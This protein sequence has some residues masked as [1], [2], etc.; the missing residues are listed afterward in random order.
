MKALI[1]T[2]KD[3]S[4][5]IFARHGWSVFLYDSF[6]ER[7]I[8]GEQF[9][10]VYFRDPFNDDSIENYKYRI[11]MV[12][13]Q[14]SEAKSIDEIRS[15]DD[16]KRI[17]DK[18]SQALLYGD[19]MPSTS[20]YSDCDFILGKHLAK[21]RISQRAKDI[22]FAPNDTLNDDWIMQEL[23]NIK[24]ELRVYSVFGEV[25]PE[26]TIKTSKTTGKVKVINKRRLSD[27]EV[28]FCK[29]VAKKSNLDFIG[30]DLA[31]LQNSDLK[32]IEVNRSP[33]FKRFVDYYGD[34]TLSAILDI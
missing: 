22:V 17:E 34:T 21:K 29:Q 27:E 32:L 12:I 25:L 33:Q 9:N 31:I 11:D 19:L 18:W 7:D 16:M 10:M 30:I 24:E 13:N 3:L 1:T 26:A 2:K 6:N 14:F 5:D 23:L 15:F 8:D 4:A 28:V 20:L